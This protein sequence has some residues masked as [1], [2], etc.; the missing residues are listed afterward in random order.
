MKY[1]IIYIYRN[2]DMD[3]IY[4]SLTS[5]KNQTMKEFEVIFVDYGSDHEYSNQLIKLLNEFS[6]C[7][8]VYVNTIGQY[9]NKSHALNIAIKNSNSE[10]IITCD[11]DMIFTNNLMENLN[12][13]VNTNSAILFF[14]YFL[15]KEFID[16][17]NIYNYKNQSIKGT[18]SSCGNHCINRKSLMEINGYDEYYI[19]W[20]AEDIDLASR[21]KQNNIDLI[22]DEEVYGFHQWHPRMDHTMP[23][24]LWSRLQNYYY[25]NMNISERNKNGWGEII[26]E[27]KIFNFLDFEKNQVKPDENIYIYTR[28]LFD[29]DNWG[30]LTHEFINLHSGMVLGIPNCFYPMKYT[31]L[32]FI[33]RIINKIIK[34]AG[35]NAGFDYRQ[36][37]L[38]AAI[39]EI[40]QEQKNNIDDY[41]INFPDKKYNGISLILKK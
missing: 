32:N 9:F 5:L 8:Y 30:D 12:K 25:K 1:S 15:P 18:S 17:N 14:A 21:Y 3:R 39:V 16:W 6:F 23:L 11:V 37:Y 41:Y 28:Y 36:N 40:I 26:T 4:R 7:K 27:R 34:T 33:L 13:L 2:R 19:Y 24:G 20:G 10:Y 22:W 35:F 31:F 38:N 29:P